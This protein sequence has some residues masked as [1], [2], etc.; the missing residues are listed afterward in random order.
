MYLIVNFTNNNTSEILK[1]PFLV[2]VGIMFNVY[3]YLYLKKAVKKDI[4]VYNDV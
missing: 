2:F 1:G 4:S 3:T